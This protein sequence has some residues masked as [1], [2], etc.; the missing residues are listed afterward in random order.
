MRGG[1]FSIYRRK[2]ETSVI[3]VPSFSSLQ[4]YLGEDG[5]RLFADANL[6]SRSA[7]IPCVSYRN[8]NYITLT[9]VKSTAVRGRMVLCCTA[10]GADVD[11]GQH[12]KS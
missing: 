2:G 6:T 7:L 10:A 9:A 3:E 1:S 4:W 8:L 5:D 11:M 12:G